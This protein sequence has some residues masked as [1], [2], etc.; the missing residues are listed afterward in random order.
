MDDARAQ[1]SMGGVGGSTFFIGALGFGASVCASEFARGSN[2]ENF[3]NTSGQGASA[4]V[5]GATMRS[6]TT[7]RQVF[8][9]S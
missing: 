7:M 2:L 3:T 9:A 5:E 8:R 1:H 6:A 4:C